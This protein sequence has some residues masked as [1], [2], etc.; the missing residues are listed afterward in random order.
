MLIAL[1]LICSMSTGDVNSCNKDNA[2]HS[3]RVPGV[4]ALPF[5]CLAEGMQFAAANQLGRDL[6]PDEMVKITCTHRFEP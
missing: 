4:F 6:Q 3:M 5:R 2:V 1:V